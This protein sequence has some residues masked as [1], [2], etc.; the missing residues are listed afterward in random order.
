MLKY[1][2]EKIELITDESMFNFIKKGLRG[3]ISSIGSLLYCKANNEFC[4]SY[5]SNEKNV[6][7]IYIDANNLY[8][9]SMS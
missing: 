6:S 8:G 3:G 5:D 9:Y 2:N 4:T 1:T 7:I